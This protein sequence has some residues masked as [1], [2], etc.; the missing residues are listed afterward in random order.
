[1]IFSRG[2][3]FFFFFSFWKPS[4]VG[5]LNLL[6]SLFLLPGFYSPKVSCLFYDTLLHFLPSITRQKPSLKQ[7]M[8]ITI[9]SQNL[10][11]LPLTACS[12]APSQFPSRARPSVALHLFIATGFRNNHSPCSWPFYPR[13]SSVHS[14]PS[15]QFDWVESLVPSGSP[16]LPFP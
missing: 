4:T 13:A 5:N 1:M 7:S 12:H 9:A 6:I 8:F 2:G 14:S 16:P 11:F 15:K 3:L 10:R